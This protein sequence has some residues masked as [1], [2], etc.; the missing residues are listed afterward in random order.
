MK[1]ISKKDYVEFMATCKNLVL[2]NLQ[3]L[4]QKEGETVDA[5]ICHSDVVGKIIFHFDKYDYKYNNKVYYICI[6]FD[7]LEKTKE[8]FGDGYYNANV[9]YTG[10]MTLAAFEDDDE[11]EI[12]CKRF[13]DL[14][15]SVTEVEVIE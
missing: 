2:K 1:R 7:E 10:K 11:K 12:C 15:E 9:G 4:E 6:Q 13:Y 8:A 14:L 5:V 3:I